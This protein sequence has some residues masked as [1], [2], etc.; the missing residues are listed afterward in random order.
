[1]N[2]GSTT[3]AEVK[4]SPKEKRLKSRPIRL[5]FQR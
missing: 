4:L 3:E 2:S 1:M 5:K